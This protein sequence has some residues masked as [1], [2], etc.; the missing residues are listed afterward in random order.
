MLRRIGGALF[1]R[2]FETGRHGLFD[3]FPFRI[4]SATEHAVVCPSR[5]RKSHA[6]AITQSRRTVASV[7][8]GDDAKH[9][10]RGLHD[11]LETFELRQQPTGRGDRQVTFQDFEFSRCYTGA[12]GQSCGRAC[13]SIRNTLEAIERRSICRGRARKRRELILKN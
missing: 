2:Q 11:G 6:L 1:L 4:S 7:S 3:V 10:E 5:Y 8:Q 9:W 12:A 13:D